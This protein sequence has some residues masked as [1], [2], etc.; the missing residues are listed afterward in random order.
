MTSPAPPRRR[1]SGHDQGA[2]QRRGGGAGGGG[3]GE[4]GGGV[5]DGVAA[6]AAVQREGFHGVRRQGEPRVPRRELRRGVAEGGRA[7]GRRRP[8][9]PHHPPQGMWS[10]NSCSGFLVP[11]AMA[12]AGRRRC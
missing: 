10:L 7:H 12:M 6:V 1:A 4:G 2:P 8:R 11:M 5:A 9:P 3:G